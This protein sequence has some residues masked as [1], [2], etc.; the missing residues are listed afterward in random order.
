MPIVTDR[1][2]SPAVREGGRGVA[3]AARAPRGAD[4]AH[5]PAP[6]RRAVARLLRRAR[7]AGARPPAARR[8]G[9]EHG[10][11]GAHPGRARAD[12]GRGAARAR[13]RL[14][15]HELHAR[16]RAGRGPGAAADWPRGGRH[17][18]VRPLDAR[19]AQP[20]A[21]RPRERPAALLDRDRGGEPGARVGRG[22]D[23]PGRRRD[24][25]RVAGLPGPRRAS[26]RPPLAERGLE[27][28][29]YLLVTAHR[30]G[31][32]DPPERLLRLVELLE[33]LPG[34]GRVP[35]APAHAPPARG[36]G[37]RSS[38][39]RARAGP[40]AGAPARLPRLP[41]A[42]PQ[43]PR[44]AHRLRRR[45]EGGLPPRRAL[46]DP[47]RHHRVG[48]D[49]GRRLERARGP[50]PRTRPSPRSSAGRPPERP[51]LY[52]GGHAAERVRDVVSAYTE[53]L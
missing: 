22:R 8:L 30:A 42:G 14:R 27:P 32:V 28:G 26:A 43:R 17:A 50:R 24:G 31:N 33:A 40:G 36:G 5:R 7:R 11:D 47:P 6:R 37:P 21:G 34:P 38:G 9:L 13:D 53:R 48:R 29:G 45:A 16:R 19:G 15:G 52:G 25:R 44:G 49:G 1:G 35:G 23:P 46:R 18:L 10:P 3:P 51:E 12:P 4:R 20:R 2:Q 41:R 39:S